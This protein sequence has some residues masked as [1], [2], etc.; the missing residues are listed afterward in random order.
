M[1]NTDGNA[2]M[3]ISMLLR[4]FSALFRLTDAQAQGGNPYELAK[5]VGVNA[6]FLPEY[7]SAL[8][9]FP[10]MKLAKAMYLLRNADLTLKSSSQSPTIV[11]QTLVIGL[12]S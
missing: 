1:L 9:H 8:R 3:I 5:I 12:L 6:Y 4:Y 7:Q 10:P 11:L 2:I